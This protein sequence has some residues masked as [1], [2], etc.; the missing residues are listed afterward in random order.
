MI[1]YDAWQK[2]NDEYLGLAIAWLRARLDAIS[3]APSTALSRIQPSAR[4]TTEIHA[5]PVEEER[6]GWFWSFFGS[7]DRQPAVPTQELPAL[8]R[9]VA[10]LIASSRPQSADPATEATSLA[11]ELA[12]RETAEPVPA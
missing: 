5:A 1:D 11:S 2:S 9:P 7:R 10:G 6:R 3:T 8:Q 4:S 12:A